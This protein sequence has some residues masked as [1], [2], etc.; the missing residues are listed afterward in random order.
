MASKKKGSCKV[1][2]LCKKVGGK[3]PKSCKMASNGKFYRLAKC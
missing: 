2:K 3:M 1:P